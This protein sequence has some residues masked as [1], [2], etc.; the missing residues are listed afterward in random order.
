MDEQPH[1]GYPV[2]QRLRILKAA[3]RDSRVA[4]AYFDMIGT[5]DR[6]WGVLGSPE[7]AEPFL[8]QFKDTPRRACHALSV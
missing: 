4:D 6:A 3:A 1:R 8:S 5:P 2:P 7:D